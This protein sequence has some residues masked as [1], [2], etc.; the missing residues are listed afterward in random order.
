MNIEGLD[1]VI[2][3]GKAKLTARSWQK[4]NP[5]L[6]RRGTPQYEMAL[7]LQAKATK[8]LTALNTTGSYTNA[9]GMKTSINRGADLDKYG[10]WSQEAVFGTPAWETQ[11]LLEANGGIESIKALGTLGEIE[12][13]MEAEGM[14][15][16]VE[17]VLQTAMAIGDEITEK[18]QGYL[19]RVAEIT[20]NIG[21]SII[22]I[23]TD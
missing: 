20:S 19:D 23:F 17:A 7:K 11:Q 5:S 12:E 22:E 6:Y 2:S 3:E 13:Q 21:Q 4:S 1:I 8:I 14:D 16:V 9:S 15:V 10:Q 18:A